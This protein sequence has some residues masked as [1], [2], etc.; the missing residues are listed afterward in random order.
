MT[1]PIKT[2]HILRLLSSFPFAIFYSSM[3]LLL[4][5]KYHLTSTNAATIV[6]CFLGL[7]YGLAVLG[8]C[9]AGKHVSYRGL[10]VWSM[11][12]QGNQVEYEKFK[13]EFD[14]MMKYMANKSKK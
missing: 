8:G 12:L 3:V 6:G 13:T 4:A 7:N 1:I 2:L 9:L 14:A 11:I 10:F 5:N